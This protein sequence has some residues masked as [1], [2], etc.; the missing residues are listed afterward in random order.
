MNKELLKG[1]TWV[2][3]LDPKLA[4]DF[5][6]VAKIADVDDT[7]IP[8]KLQ[9]LKGLFTWTKAKF[10]E[11]YVFKEGDRV[12]TIDH[13]PDDWGKPP[14]WIPHMDDKYKDREGI[15][16][17]TVMYIRVRFSDG[18]IY[19]FKPSWLIPILDDSESKADVRPA[20]TREDI[21]V[22]CAGGTARKLPLINTTQLLTHIK[23]D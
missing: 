8:Y 1:G 4:K 10:V 5:G 7:A 20:L 17:S 6:E 18:Q 13:R 3:V 16:V 21:S 11:P 15:V 12:K 9:S 23:L 2:R 22:H 19:L 14:T